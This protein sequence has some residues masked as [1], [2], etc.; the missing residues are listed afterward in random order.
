MESDEVVDN[1][2][3]T[4]DTVGASVMVCVDEMVVGVTVGDFAILVEVSAG[5]M[6]VISVGKVAVVKISV[7]KVESGEAWVVKIVS[8]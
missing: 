8:W 5:K 2:I 6:V 7:C 4:E 1:E 3:I